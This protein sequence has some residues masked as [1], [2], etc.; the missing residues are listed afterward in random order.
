MSNIEDINKVGWKPK[1]TAEFS[2]G[3]YD[4]KRINDTLV[5]VDEISSIVNSTDIPSLPMMQQFFA[6]LKNLSDNFRAII[7][8]PIVIKEVDNLVLEGKKHKRIW[9]KSNKVGA[10]MN[11]VWILNF[12]D[13][14]NALKTKLYYIKQ[15][16]GLGI[17]V[18]RNLSTAEKIK[19]G[20][21]GDKNFSNL[22]EA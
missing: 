9:E 22:P 2:M 20:V 8:N 16:I 18:K 17:V 15:I 4:Y 1:F 6:H 21:Y 14:L 19:K 3:E 10:G 5:K 11:E 13:V 12:V 7:S